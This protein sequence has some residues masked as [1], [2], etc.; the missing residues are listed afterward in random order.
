MMITSSSPA[1]RVT[2]SSKRRG[3]D[4]SS[5]WDHTYGQGIAELNLSDQVFEEEQETPISPR[6]ST[7]RGLVY[8]PTNDE[9]DRIMWSGWDSIGTG[10]KAQLVLHVYL[11]YTDAQRSSFRQTIIVPGISKRLTGMGLY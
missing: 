3:S 9:D 5:H 1:S 4:N 6:S 2:N 8:Y 7:G 10:S 11:F